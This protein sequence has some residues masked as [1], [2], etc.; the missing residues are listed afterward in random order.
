MN[1]SCSESI[2]RKFNRCAGDARRGP[3]RPLVVSGG[4]EVLPAD[5]PRQDRAHG[6]LRDDTVSWSCRCPPPAVRKGSGVPPRRSCTLPRR[7][8]TMGLLDELE[9]ASGRFSH[10]DTSCP[11]HLRRESFRG[12]DPRR[13]RAGLSLPASAA[14][15]RRDA[16][17]DDLLCGMV[18]F[19]G[20]SDAGG[21]LAHVYSLCL[22]R[23]TPAWRAL[24]TGLRLEALATRPLGDR[25]SRAPVSGSRWHSEAMCWVL[26]SPKL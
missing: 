14:R 7:R 2:H 17:V 22:A 12:P 11:K 21:G 3:D 16:D 8:T 15:G 13:K 18:T 23:R 25:S 6:A 19:P 20:W 9:D 24:C 4:T 26:P 10:G 5:V 1:A